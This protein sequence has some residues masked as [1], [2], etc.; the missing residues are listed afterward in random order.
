VATIRDALGEEAFAA[1]W[2]QGR[3]MTLEDA[4]EYALSVKELSPPTVAPVR[5]QPSAEPQHLLTPREEE[6]A[7][8]VAQGMTNRSIAEELVVS[9]RTVGTHVRRMLKKLDLRSR[10]QIAAWVTSRRLHDNEDLQ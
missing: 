8:L 3:E 6:I 2:A 7:V 1:A 9:E 4:V 5:G 10:A